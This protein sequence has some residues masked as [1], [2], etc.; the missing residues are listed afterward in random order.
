VSKIVDLNK[1]RIEK[2]LE[3]LTNEIE[4]ADNT[5]DDILDEI[6]AVL[7]EY[8]FTDRDEKFAKNFYYV[9]E[10]VR[11]LVFGYHGV[12]H[13]FQDLSQEF[14]EAKWNAKHNVWS[15]GWKKDLKKQQVEKKLYF[16]DDIE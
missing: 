3:S 7:V 11:S 9:M 10:S 13:P 14:V 1:R 6:D 15:V 5:V 12:K 2:K 8:G 16:E 4:N